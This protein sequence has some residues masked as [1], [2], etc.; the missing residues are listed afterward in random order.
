MFAEECPVPLVPAVTVDALLQI[1]VEFP[2]PEPDREIRF[3][4]ELSWIT[5]LQRI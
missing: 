3:D 1:N 4:E 5:E 2:L